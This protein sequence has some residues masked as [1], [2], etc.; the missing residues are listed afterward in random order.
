MSRY[1]CTILNLRCRGRGGISE[2]LERVEQRTSSKVF[3][4][5]ETKQLILLE[6]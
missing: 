2:S 1:V 5:Y 3:A 4:L 6:S